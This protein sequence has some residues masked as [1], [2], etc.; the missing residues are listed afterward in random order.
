M[1]RAFCSCIAVL[2]GLCFVYIGR[3]MS[4]RAVPVAS[5]TPTAAASERAAGVGVLGFARQLLRHKNFW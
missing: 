3:K 5:G 4:E 2:A 1:F